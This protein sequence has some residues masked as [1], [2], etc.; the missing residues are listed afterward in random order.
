MLLDLL[1][2]R[3]KVNLWRLFFF[4]D[5]GSRLGPPVVL[6]KTFCKLVKKVLSSHSSHFSWSGILQDRSWRWICFFMSAVIILFLSLLR[7]LLAATSQ[8][9]L[10]FWMLAGFTSK[11]EYHTWAAFASCD[12]VVAIWVGVPIAAPPALLNCANRFVVGVCC[13]CWL[14][15]ATPEGDSRGSSDSCLVFLFSGHFVFTKLV[16]TFV[17]S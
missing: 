12:C 11:S 14:G 5:M 13:C 4:W 8:F 2:R 6:P 15:P 3:R 10:N 16:K 9:S 7:V 1:G 17:A